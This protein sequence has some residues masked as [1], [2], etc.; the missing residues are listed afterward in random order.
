MYNHSPIAKYWRRIMLSLSIVLIAS[1]GFA[2]CSSPAPT[3][4]TTAYVVTQHS[5]LTVSVITVS[6][7]GI[8]AKVVSA[9]KQGA[10]AHAVG[11]IAINYSDGLVTTYDPGHHA[12]STMPLR[13]MV[14]S[15]IAED[16]VVYEALSSGPPKISARSQPAPPTTLRATALKTKIDG[17]EADAY[18]LTQGQV[19]HRLWYARGLPTP[20]PAI[21]ALI[22]ELDIARFGG[23]SGIGV[24]QIAG[25]V[26][27]RAEVQLKVNGD[28]VWQ[29]QVDT[30]SVIRTQLYA[31]NQPQ[32]T[33]STSSITRSAHSQPAA[34]AHAA[35]TSSIPQSLR[36]SATRTRQ[37]L[38]VPARVVL[39][40][41]DLSNSPNIYAFYWGPK[42]SHSPTFLN[43]MDI[44][45]YDFYDPV[46]EGPLAQYQI[47][48]GATTDG[49][50]G[51]RVIDSSDPTPGVGAS[52]FAAVLLF[53][54]EHMATLDGP[55]IWWKFGNDPIYAIFVQQNEVDS[56]NWKGYH[57]ISP[58]FALLLPWPVDLLAHDFMPYT[59]VKVPDAAL[60]IRIED[61][62]WLDTCDSDHPA[63]VC[64]SIL[65]GFDQA[66]EFA[67]HEFV[68][69]ATDPI[70]FT[71][72][73]D[74]LQ[75]PVWE[76]GE[77][78][79]ICEENSAPWGSRTTMDQYVVAT[80]WSNAAGACVP[81]SRP[82]IHIIYPADHTKIPWLSNIGVNAYAIDPI[83]GVLTNI[84]WYLDG[85]LVAHG[86]S[87]IISAPNIGAHTIVAKAT[88]SQKPPLIAGTS[89]TVNVAAKPPTTSITSPRNG[90]TVANDQLISL[91]GTGHD[92]Q[93]GNLSG[94]NL[95]WRVNGSTVG[96]GTS[97]QLKITKIGDNTI[98][99]TATNTAGLSATS[100]VIIHVTPAT[101]N[102]SVVITQPMDD[103]VLSFGW[104]DPVTFSADVIDPAGMPL[105]GATIQWTDHV[106]GNPAI[107]YTLGTGSEVHH[108]LTGGG[109]GL[110]LNEITAKFTDAAGRSAADT[111]SVWVGQ[112]C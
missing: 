71:G 46:Y 96:Y 15:H 65:P 110:E 50:F 77:I 49:L 38:D 97:L 41:G 103:S 98:T 93:E 51:G 3:Q 56:S 30:T 23:V 83:D 24:H 90:D 36:P 63:S 82:S 89:I 64:A 59:L 11:T 2:G 40:P 92:P 70:T 81:E 109:C 106:P 62:L 34:S 72:W 61:I 43:E 68:E 9:E 52:N 45:Q 53:M 60:G 66:T 80:Y 76:K 67:S 55:Q 1:L 112:I 48:G 17:V 88:D 99:L 86:T 104:R 94:P 44:A 87:A 29:R 25:R 85:H 39:G 47:H 57:F 111:I 6:E 91:R 5:G 26:L 37:P 28:N 31:L 74:P 12:S 75:V 14:G 73:S 7:M 107:D 42:F 32:S 69:T 10:A 20:P 95:T 27:L 35:S 54:G 33:P 79:D 13:E 19:I 4:P 21:A 105:D 84:D 101:G 18:L 78:G 8:S 100:S 22:A 102:P 108:T 58:S 16:T